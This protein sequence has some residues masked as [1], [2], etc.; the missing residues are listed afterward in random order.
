VKSARTS[1]EALRELRD[2]YVEMLSMRIEHGAGD[3]D[4]TRARERMARLA[5]RFPGALREIDELELDAIRARIVAL[6]AVL[7][8]RAEIEEWMDAVA[9]FHA[10]ARGALLAK[11]WLAGRKR[12]DAALASAYVRG[13]VELEFSS[14]A[15]RWSTA[16]HRIAKPPRGRLMDLV[17]ARVAL[18]L[19]ITHVRARALVFRPRPRRSRPQR[20]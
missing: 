11:R 18:D 14:D 10:L 17:F 7:A 15:L 16:L 9:L 19:G 4:E 20:V 6:E 12:V 5:A 8:G 13:A 2:K 1:H 3:E